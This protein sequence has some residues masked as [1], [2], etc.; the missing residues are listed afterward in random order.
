VE[1][2]GS[3]LSGGHYVAYIRRRNK[4]AESVSQPSSMVY[5]EDDAKKGDWF[6]V[7]D[8]QVKKLAG[9]FEAL[10]KCEAYM[11]FYERLPMVDF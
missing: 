3:S 8:R 2:R 4:V 7:N 10:K 1:H 5:D 11:L 9:G 6:F